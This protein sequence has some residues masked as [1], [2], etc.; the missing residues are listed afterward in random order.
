MK[1]LGV[2]T[3][4][5]DTSMAIVS[6]G[7]LISMV[8]ATSED[9]HK[10]Y[11]GVVPEIAARKQL[12]IFPF[13]L[14]D[15]E[16][17]SGISL[18]K[19]DGV[20][21][22]IGPGLV[23]SLLVGV[24][25]AKTISYSLSIPLIGV[26]HLEGHIYSIFFDHNLE[27]P[28]LSLIIS[29]GHT[30][31]LIVEENLKYKLLGETV[32]DSAGEVIDKIGRRLGFDYPAGKMLDELALKGDPNRFK[33][34]IPKF[35]DKKKRYSFSFSGLKTEVLN[36]I[37]KGD[38]KV[39]DLVSSM[40]YSIYESLMRNIKLA[41]DEFRINKVSVVG[42]VSASKFLRKYFNLNSNFEFY[43]PSFEFSTDNGGM[44]ALVGEKYFLE[45]YFSDYNLDAIASLPINKNPYLKKK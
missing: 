40:F 34:S 23:G 28:F 4:C 44:I 20:S 2:E 3:S 13:V 33:F 25:F 14:E 12:E 32:D 35:K 18:D 45:G 9:F 43:F 11:G 15:L 16:K 41:Y 38:Y 7:K 17:K 26:N 37:N 5:D 36:I 8:R 31:L 39:E 24:E 27:F 1:V 6:D 21:V 19:I 30:I 10:S 29:G 42:G 22:T